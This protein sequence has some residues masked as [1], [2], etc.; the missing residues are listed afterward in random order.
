MFYAKS[1]E[2]KRKIEGGGS[3][4]LGNKLGDLVEHLGLNVETHTYLILD[5]IVTYGYVEF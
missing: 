5:Y 4:E 2:Y 1:R 3:A